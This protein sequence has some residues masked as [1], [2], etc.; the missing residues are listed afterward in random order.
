MIPIGADPG[1]A[2]DYVI[3]INNTKQAINHMQIKINKCFIFIVNQNKTHKILF[4]ITK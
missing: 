4:I 1:A 3:K 2:H